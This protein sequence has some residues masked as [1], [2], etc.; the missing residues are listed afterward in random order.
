CPRD[1]GLRLALAEGRHLVL[2]HFEIAGDVWTDDVGARGEELAEL[3][4]SR[5]EPRRSIMR[6]RP[7]AQTTGI[8]RPRVSTRPSTPSR[9]NTKPARERRTRCESVEI[10]TSSPNAAPRRHRS[11]AGS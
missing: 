10:T 11:S 1:S 3:D 9:A 7:T 6:P 4:V 2:Q 8:G 5:P